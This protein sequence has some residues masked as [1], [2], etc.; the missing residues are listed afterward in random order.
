MLMKIGGEKSA[1]AAGAGIHY[2]MLIAAKV[3]Y[4][5]RDSRRQEIPWVRI[6]RSDGSVTEFNS[7]SAPLTGGK[8]ERCLSV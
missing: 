5:A 1:L 4:I 6:R 7:T 2:H 8:R 3:E